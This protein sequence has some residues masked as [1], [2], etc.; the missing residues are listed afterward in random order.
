MKA[1]Q[2]LISFPS[3]P[4]FCDEWLFA[5]EEYDYIRDDQVANILTAQRELLHSNYGV[6]MSAYAFFQPD[7]RHV[8]GYAYSEF[9]SLCYGFG[10]I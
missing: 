10:Y 2:G 1:G 4:G 6:A 3:T 8:H 9:V 7:M 5:E